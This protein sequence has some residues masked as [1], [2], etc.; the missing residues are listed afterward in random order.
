MI[1][2]LLAVGEIALL[3][4][5]WTFAGLLLLPR[6]LR[7]EEDSLLV[8]TTALA[9]GAG[10]SAI[11]IT[12]LAALHRLSRGSTLAVAAAVAAAGVVAIW[13]LRPRWSERFPRDRA[14]RVA[15]AALAAMG[16]ITL[17]ATLGPPSSMDATVYHLRV[18]KEF[19][20]T[21]GWTKI[22]VLQSFQ[23]LYVEML[24]AEG[25]ALG[26]GTVAA[27]AHWV[28][29]IG[30]VGASA[31]WG[32]RLGGGASGLW[33]ALAFGGTALWAWE[34]TSAFIDLGLAL[35]AGLAFYWATRPDR[36][37][38]SVVLAGAFAGLAG[39]SKFT[40][41]IAAAL[42]AVAA[43]AIAWPDVRRGV[44]RMLGVGGIALLVASPWYLRN[45][46]LT[47]NPIYPLLNKWFHLPVVMF[48]RYEYGNGRDLLHL[49]I[50]PVD[51]LVRG[52]A[53]SEGW[54]V[55][56]AF[57]IL[58]PVGLIARRSRA[59]F[60]GAGIIAAW[61]LVWFWSSPQVRL[62]LPIMPIGAGLAGAGFC[63]C[64]GSRS[65]A[66]RV[67]A[68]AALAVATAEGLGIAALYAKVN[69]KVVL[70]LEDA[71]TFLR[72][73]SWNYVAYEQTNRLL[74][75][76]A[77][78]ATTGTAL[79]N[80]LYYLDREASFLGG[81]DILGA[82]LHQAGFTHDLR[83]VECPLAPAMPGRVVIKEGE[84]PLRASRLRGGVKM[85][86]CYRLSA[87]R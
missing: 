25:I 32:R 24:F 30:A 43:F 57:L 16:A 70:G 2:S 10:V 87:L 5:S 29:A 77:K 55:G 41:L 14:A 51:L 18:P 33:A 35:F 68:V 49:L 82:E 20:R 54:S 40:G 86:V 44:Q 71:S 28:L 60:V 7:E 50:S 81:D 37:W 45:L 80:N 79:W 53:F 26:G 21:G 3:A 15:L 69:E 73:H 13:R 63:A 66:A 74:P 46:A 42:A 11:A 64:F 27:L 22:D 84:Y 8:W 85:Q 56:P 78:V 19:L 17:F 67:L 61:W 1:S 39:G 23:P 58:A 34:S 65:R 4:V 38:P 31:A 52:T 72:Q 76:D 47:G 83:V 62:L 9:L 12:G 59:A 36:G 48:S 6:Q 75:A